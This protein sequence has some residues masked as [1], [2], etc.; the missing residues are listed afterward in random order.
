MLPYRSTNDMDNVTKNPSFQVLCQYFK[1]H[2]RTLNSKDAIEAVKILC[3]LKVPVESLIMQ[4]VLQI[5]R[6][7]V[8]ELNIRE[9]M[10]L[11][12]V[13][14][15]L[16]TR[17]HLV[18]ALKLALP[19]AFQIHLPLELDRD[20]LPLLRD[21]LSY[22]CTHELP[23]RC[24]NNIVTGLLLHNNVMNE[25]IAKNIIWS[26]TYGNCTVEIYPTRVQLLTVCF[27]VMREN[28][29]KFNYD[30]ILRTTG[31]LKSRILQKHPEYYNERFMDAVADYVVRN[32]MDFEKSMLI[33]RIL[34]RVV[35]WLK[36]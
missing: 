23:D 7:K 2:V 12:F 25:K 35:S 33:A 3:Y 16:D 24:V 14:T 17:N 1:K 26:L 22:A 32:D 20:D 15:K 34:S 30:D 13:L 31:K 11:H 21:M 8:N 19:L 4:S 9:I 10:F 6:G 27:D 29:D 18:D 5:I 28:M 36:T